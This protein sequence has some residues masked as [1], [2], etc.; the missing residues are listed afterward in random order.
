MTHKF[1]FE[2]GIING[3]DRLKKL[4]FS[5]SFSGFDGSLLADRAGYCKFF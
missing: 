5:L 2:F 1:H 4:S 3:K